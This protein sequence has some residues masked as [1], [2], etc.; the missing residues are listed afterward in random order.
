MRSLRACVCRFATDAFCKAKAD[1]SGC[2]RLFVLC[3]SELNFSRAELFASMKSTVLRGR[4]GEFRG[5]SRSQLTFFRMK[6]APAL[7]CLLLST[8]IRASLRFARWSTSPQTRTTACGSL[9]NHHHG[10]RRAALRTASS[11]RT[12]AS[13]GAMDYQVQGLSVQPSSSSCGSSS[14]GHAFASRAPQFSSSHHIPPP[15]G[16][17]MGCA[18]R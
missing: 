5:S 8:H 11:R 12:F 6:S 10:C 16:A 3:R 15:C 9:G 18:G 14:T 17:M 4:W 1:R 7:W 13:V 2:G